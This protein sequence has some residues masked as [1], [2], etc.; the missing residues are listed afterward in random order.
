MRMKKTVKI[1]LVSDNHG[2]TDGLD[3]VIETHRDADYFIHCGDAELPTWMVDRFSVVQ[4][5]NDNY[6]QFPSNLVMPLGTHKAYICHGHRDMFFGN[7]DMLA[8]KAKQNGCDLCF[9]GHTHIPFNQLIDGV[10]VINPGSIWHNRDGSEPSY[11]IVTLD[12][13]GVKVQR[14]IYRKEKK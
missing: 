2:T 14:M 8:D 10:R 11:A 7:F 5:N 3:Y 6:N 1:I 4:G 13:D 9:F 12:E